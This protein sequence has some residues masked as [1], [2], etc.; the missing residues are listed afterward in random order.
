MPVQFY[1]DPRLADDPSTRD[2]KDI[3]LSYEFFLSR[4]PQAATDLAR[5]VVAGPPDA[6][7]GAKLFATNCAACHALNTA[8]VGPPLAGVV[9]RR[10]GSVSGYPYTAALAGFHQTWTPAELAKWLT[11]PQGL[12]PGTAMPM[13]VADA[14]DR[15]DIIAYLATTGD[16]GATPPR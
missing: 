4:R 7:R 8:K 14:Q 16:T 13:A 9:G 11:N 3:T 5:F 1:V 10:A 2:V 12:V 6:A 15:V